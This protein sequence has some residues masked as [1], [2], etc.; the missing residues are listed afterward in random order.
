MTFDGPWTPEHTREARALADQ[1]EMNTVTITISS[2]F[3]QDI[4]AALRAA[5]AALDSITKDRDDN[6]DDALRLHREKMDYF[7]QLASERETVVKLR[8]ALE[9][10]ATGQP[11]V[12]AK[13]RQALKETAHE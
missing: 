8:A 7:D 13:A 3:A 11:D 4:R 12:G 9:F 6:H 5:C 10:Y 1:L 2:S